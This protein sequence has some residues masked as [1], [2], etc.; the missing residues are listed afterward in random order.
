MEGLNYDVSGYHSPGIHRFGVNTVFF[1]D[2]YLL[3]SGKE[4]RRD[5]EQETKQSVRFAI[6][7]FGVPY[8]KMKE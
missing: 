7:G 2:G 3:Q 5:W 6:S 1:S 4:T 8:Q